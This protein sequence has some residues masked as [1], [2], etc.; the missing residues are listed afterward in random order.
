VG[1]VKSR[2]STTRTTPVTKQHKK[3][4]IGHLKWTLP[5]IFLASC[6]KYI[7]PDMEEVRKSLKMQREAQRRRALAPDN[8]PFRRSFDLQW[9]DGL[10]VDAQALLTPDQPLVLGAG[11]EIVPPASMGLQ[12]L[13]SIIGGADLLNLGASRQRTELIDKAG[14]LELA[15]ETANQQDVKGPVQK[16]IAHQLAAAHKRGI[17]LMAESAQAKDPDISIKKAR[18]SAR[19]MDA[20]SRSALTLQRLQSGGGQTIQV[21]YMQVNSMVGD[22]S[23]KMQNI[24]STNT[25]VNKGGRP[26]TSGY[27]TQEAISQRSSDRELL[28]DMKRVEDIG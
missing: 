13:E 9:A 15:L 14:V 19:L 3:N 21:Q 18:A 6:I 7:G 26:P 2:F 8:D 16:M 23:G 5:I 25:P 22:A 20:F 12:G 24:N 11:G 4:K 27:R 10:E 28:S 1:L 17:E